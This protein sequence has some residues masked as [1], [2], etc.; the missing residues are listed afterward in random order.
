MKVYE[1]KKLNETKIIFKKTLKIRLLRK[2]AHMLFS[3]NLVIS[4]KNRNEHH[5]RDFNCERTDII[6]KTTNLH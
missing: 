4:Y 3:N 6:F 5:G 1:T 2:S